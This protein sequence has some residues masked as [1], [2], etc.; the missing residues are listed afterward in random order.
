MKVLDGLR[1]YE[2]DDANVV[3]YDGPSGNG[4]VQI[5]FRGANNRVEIAPDANLGRLSLV[6]DCDNGLVSIAGSSGVPKFSASIRVGQDSSVAIGR[7]VSTTNQCVISATEGSSVVLGEDIMMASQNRL[8]ADD[9]HPIFD[10][11][12]GQRVNPSRPITVGNHVWLAVG[13]VLLGGADVGDGSVI[14][15]QSLVTGRIPNN[16]IAVGSPARV[17][18]RDIAWERPHL[19][20]VKPYYKPD[21]STV[22]RSPYWKPTQD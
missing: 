14:G 11:H 12:T 7:N 21:A 3:Q 22:V 18:R 16:C 8:R 17:V 13:A 9:G 2:D 6:F 4:V 1:P 19:S 5:R 15:T 10:V 20:L